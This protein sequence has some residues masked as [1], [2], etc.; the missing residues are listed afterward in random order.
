MFL[1]ING[2][3]LADN[4]TAD[5]NSLTLAGTFGK[6][7]YDTMVSNS[8]ITTPV[9]ATYYSRNGTE[10]LPELISFNTNITA[11][12]LTLSFSKPVRLS[13]LMNTYLQPSI[14]STM[15][16]IPISYT[17]LTHPDTTYTTVLVTLSPQDTVQLA[18]SPLL[19]AA[20]SLLSLS[21]GNISDYEDNTLSIVVTTDTISM[22]HSTGL[23]I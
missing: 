10:E 9:E 22:S 12:L 14:N 23:T 1:K 19:G 2:T 18:T 7:A 17:A 13:S 3:D 15:P 8:A 11:G 4:T 20:S 21:I 16:A 6:A 5:Y